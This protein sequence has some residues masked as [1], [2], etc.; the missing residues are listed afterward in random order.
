MELMVAISVII[1][2]LTAAASMIFSNLRI[3]EISSD[4]VVASN[5]ARQGVEFAK[6]IRDSN[7][8][9]GNAFNTG[10][11]SG[12]DYTAVPIMNTSGVFTGFDFTAST[13]D[14]DNWTVVKT[15]SVAPTAGALMGQGPSFTGTTT[16]FKRL[17]TMQPICSDGTIRVEGAACVSPLYVVGIRI[18]SQ[19]IW[20]R[21][22]S[23][24]QSVIVDEIYDWR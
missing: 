22:G 9:A 4:R 17:V 15:S 21:R 16:I 3:Q 7:W 11:Q 12:T 1:I 20:D 18:T 19:A 2:G 23:R 6:S 8:L 14:T 24:R 5:L 13:I 10:L